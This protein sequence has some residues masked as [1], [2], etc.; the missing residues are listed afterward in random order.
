MRLSR[1]IPNASIFAQQKI[2][3]GP[4]GKGVGRKINRGANGK[5]KTKK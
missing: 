1:I 4:T 2:R 5:N 3:L